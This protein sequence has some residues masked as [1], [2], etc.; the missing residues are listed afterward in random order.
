[1]RASPIPLVFASLVPVFAHTAYGATFRV[2]ST[3]SDNC[4]F[5]SLQPAIDAAASLGGTNHIVVA[6]S[7]NYAG[8]A[9]VIGDQSLLIEGG[10]ATCATQRPSSP[11]DISG[12]STDPVLRIQPSS[13]TL[14]YVSLRGLHLHDG[15][16][17]GVFGTLGGGIYV[18]NNVHLHL[19]DVRVDL[20]QAVDGGGIYVDA[21]TGKPAVQLDPGTLIVNNHATYYGGGIAL[22]GGGELYVVADN[23][24]ID[25]NRSDDAGGG[26]FATNGYVF[27]GNPDNFS[28]RTDATGASVSGNSAGAVGGGIYLFGPFAALQANE[29]I[30]DGNS[31]ATRGG[32]IAAE[33][34]ARVTMQRDYG[35]LL[36]LQCPNWRE[37]SRLS[38]NSVGAGAPGTLGGALAFSGAARADIAQTIVR[39]NIAQDGSAAY[40]DGATLN[41]EGALVTANRSADVPGQAGVVLRTHF[42]SPAQ[43][44]VRIAYS[45][46]AGNVETAASNG[47]AIDIVAQQYTQLDI[48]SSAFYDAYYPITTYSSYVDDCVVSGNAAGA[49]GS[50]TRLLQFAAGNFNNPDA[51]DYRLR[52]ESPANDY[53]DASAYTA[54]FRDLVLTPRCHDDS[55]KFDIF[56][57]CDVGAYES[58][59]VFGNGL[60]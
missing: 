17:S 32:G 35:V 1:M 53:C 7:G 14:Q 46:F 30:V 48:Y 18:T 36:P 6:N 4:D 39:G 45:T 5:D 58:D 57:T 49:N 28:A 54:A 9:L 51:G 41:F 11:A 33:G 37:C 19:A 24:H 42:L 38:N 10:F 43:A 25:G 21:S 23:V 40:V 15:G 29:L 12:N 27:V 59:H 8:Q 52:N 13:S 50:H 34:K 55:R 3:S 56:G 47:P 2:G 31:A 22:D 16:T 26:I 44:N 20:N 60:Q